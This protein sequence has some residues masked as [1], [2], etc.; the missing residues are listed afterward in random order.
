M[1][2]VLVILALFISSILSAQDI[3]KMDLRITDDSA[4][5]YKIVTDTS[6]TNP[7]DASICADRVIAYCQFANIKSK[8]NSDERSFI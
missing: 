5:F 8:S 4:K 1:K 3:R 6:I 7:L 2:S